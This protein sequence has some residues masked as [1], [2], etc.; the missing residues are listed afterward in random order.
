MFTLEFSYAGRHGKSRLMS[1]FGLLRNTFLEDTEAQFY[2]RSVIKL[3]EVQ[4]QWHF[5]MA[6]GSGGGGYIAP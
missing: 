5:T 4:A 2:G 6:L 3:D 1:L